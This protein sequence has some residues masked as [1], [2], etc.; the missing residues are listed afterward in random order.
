MKRKCDRCGET[1]S[2]FMMSK[3]NTDNLCRKCIDKEKNHPRYKEASEAEHQAVVNGDYNYPGL[4]QGE[5]ITF[6]P[7]C[8]ECANFDRYENEDEYGGCWEKH[9][10]IHECASAVDCPDFK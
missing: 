3:L 1:N 4:L 6:P 2:A 10:T 8:G 7:T 5:T 9:G